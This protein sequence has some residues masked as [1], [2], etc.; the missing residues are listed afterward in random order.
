MLL[1]FKTEFDA[2]DPSEKPDCP[3]RDS[4][5]SAVDSCR[6]QG[7]RTIDWLPWHLASMTE[8]SQNLEPTFCWSGVDVP[9][10]RLRPQNAG[11]TPKGRTADPSDPEGNSIRYARFSGRSDRIAVSKGQLL[12]SELP[13]QIRM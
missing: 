1:S 7:L 12:N 4:T 10:S 8:R 9:F 3:E 5:R 6:I 13:S 2:P 11:R